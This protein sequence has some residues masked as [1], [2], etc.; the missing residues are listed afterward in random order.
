[1]KW[2]TKSDFAVGISE[3]T[4]YREKALNHCGFP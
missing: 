1:M 3:A 4:W 2:A